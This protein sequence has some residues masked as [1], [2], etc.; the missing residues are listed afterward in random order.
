M[1]IAGLKVAEYWHVE[2]FVIIPLIVYAIWRVE[3][4]VSLLNTCPI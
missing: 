3:T 1:K 2:M 4:I